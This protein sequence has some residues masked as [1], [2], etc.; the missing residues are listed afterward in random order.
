MF[1]FAPKTITDSGSKVWNI[2]HGLRGILVTIIIEAGHFGYMI[3][4]RTGHDD[5]RSLQS[6]Q[7]LRIELGVRQQHDILSEIDLNE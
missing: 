2:S 6:Y 4:L 1:F 5:P 7:Y 3:C